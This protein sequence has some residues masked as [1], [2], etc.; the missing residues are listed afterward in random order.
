MM[1]A[2]EE[3]KEGIGVE[4]WLQRRRAPWL[5]SQ[6]SAMPRFLYLNFRDDFA[7]Y[8]YFSLVTIAKPLVSCILDERTRFKIRTA[9]PAQNLCS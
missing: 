8:E 1:T 9:Q 6:R 5:E 2:A 7:P 3:K 4:T